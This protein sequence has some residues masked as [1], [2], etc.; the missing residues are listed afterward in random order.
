MRS[1]NKPKGILVCFAGI[2]GGGK[3]TLAEG[4]VDAVTR[5]GIR[6]SYVWGGF[7]RFV[8]LRPVVAL[9]Q[10]VIPYQDK[11]VKCSPTKGSEIQNP[12]L[13]T[14]YH[15]LV[16]IDYVLQ[17]TIKIRLPLLR[18]DTIICDRYVYDVIASIG[19]ILDYP[20]GRTL[21]LLD[22][23]LA[24]LPKPHLAFVVDLPEALAYQRKEDIISID[25]LSVRRQLYLQMAE[26]HG[27]T[28]LDGSSDPSE[29]S[30]LVAG[31]VLRYMA[32]DS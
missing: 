15:Y 30:N 12:V 28:V 3:T 16:L 27:M 6:T 23:C 1:D 4:L 21:A 25:F 20:A 13:A 26:R 9:A 8:L 18:G 17:A 22:S 31:K 32:E 2:D 5:S 11:R 10:A 7:K 14:V 29:L 19:V 24:L